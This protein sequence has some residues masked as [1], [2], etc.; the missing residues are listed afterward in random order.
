M[1]SIVHWTWTNELHAYFVV[2]NVLELDW[3]VEKNHLIFFTS[4]QK[5]LW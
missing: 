4:Q 5:K 2:V 3:I 1:D